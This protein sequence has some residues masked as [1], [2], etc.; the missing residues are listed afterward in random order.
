MVAS[1][2]LHKLIKSLSQAEKRFFKIYASRHVIGD[3]NDYVKLFDVIAAQTKY[4]EKAVIS[5][6]RGSSFL[7]RFPAVKNYLQET[8]I[9]SMRHFHSGSSIDNE[10]KEMVMDIEFLYHKGS[11][12][13]CEKIRKKAEKLALQADKKSRML[14]ILE[15]KAKLEQTKNKES[16]A[17]NF[18]RNIYQEEK[19]ILSSISRSLEIK[20]EVLD[21]FSLIRK[22]G[23]ARTEKELGLIKNVLNK[24]GD[25]DYSSLSFS[26]KYYLNYIHSVYYSS[27]GNHRES[28]RY[29][30]RNL[31]LLEHIPTR[32][33]EEEFEK[34]IVALNNLVVNLIH[35][36][37][38][39]GISGYIERIRSLA[40]HNI[41]ENVLLWLTSYKLVLGVSISTGD[42]EQASRIVDELSKGMQQHSGKIPATEKVLLKY[43]MASVHFINRKHSLALQ[44]LNE[45]INDNENALRSDIQ[46]FARIMRLIILWEK[47][48]EEMLPGAAMSVYRFLS[49]RKKLFKFENIVL[50]FIRDELPQ[51]NTR[52]RQQVA[53]ER[54]LNQLETLAKDAFEKKVLEYFDFITWVE[55]KLKRKDY[56]VIFN[57][58]R[59]A[60]SSGTR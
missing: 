42:F 34:Q 4:D 14:E 32:M 56:R 37:N 60:L 28:L 43:N 49:K 41:R 1:E 15:W 22:E 23:F 57:E 44:E 54:F 20:S 5:H 7:K 48:E 51:M 36:N 59:K 12:K 55:S 58:K 26:D 11:Y 2:D 13:L 25:L 27:S 6:F 8:I 39:E 47:G 17:E 33:L 3:K 31:E 21:V 38:Y 46:S 10:L 16:I 24:Y 19:K 35:L 53:F 30:Q 29:S 40:T 52:S 45:I 18:H 50:Q 9:I